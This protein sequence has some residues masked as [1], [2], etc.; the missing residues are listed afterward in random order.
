[1]N[2]EELVTF[3]TEEA[4]D[5]KVKLGLPDITFAE[6]DPDKIMSQLVNLHTIIA[7][8]AI[9]P[10]DPVYL[11]FKVIAYAL[12]AMRRRIDQAGKQ[13]LLAY[14]LHGGLDHLGVLVGTA[15]V[16]AQKAQAT[17]DITLSG[18]RPTTVTVPK[19]TRITAGDNVFFELT[20]EVSIVPGQL[21]ATGL[22]KCQVAGTA[23]NG[24]VAGQLNQIVDPVAWVA[25]IVNTDT[26]A[27]GTELEKDE[28]FRER[29]H[30][31]P[32]SFSSAGPKGAYEYFA[33]SANTDI[34]DIYVEAPEDRIKNGTAERAGEVDIYVLMN[35][36][37]L[38]EEEVLTQVRVA[39]S[40]KT[41]RPLTDKVTVLKPTK[42]EF[43]F[44]AT[45]YIAKSDETTAGAIRQ[46]VDRAV[47]DYISWQRSKLGRDI[48]P[49][50]LIR[51]I[52]EAGAKRVEPAFVHTIVKDNEV[53]WATQQNIT[54]GGL[55]D[56]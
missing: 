56:D 43:N 32:E 50:E 20:K 22:V 55:E 37:E 53:A 44:S 8:R 1:M 17:V 39:C 28:P 52:M 7:G 6:S 10:A 23:G 9:A 12:V 41:V 35:G 19:G 5:L 3:D 31:A 15:R 49:S 42:K 34:A 29:I 47:Q 30:L 54:Y 26:S 45:Y 27:G 2:I 51:K 46:A 11:T 33:L 24:Y 16:R 36:G 18:K 4:S 48:E 40:N 38:P 21:K 25:S 14:S 13:N